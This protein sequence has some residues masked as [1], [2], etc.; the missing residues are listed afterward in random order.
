MGRDQMGSID[1]LSA[2]G[3]VPPSARCG[4]TVWGST[5]SAARGITYYSLA[6]PIVYGLCQAVH[7]QASAKPHR[8][9]LGDAAYRRVPSGTSLRPANALV[10]RRVPPRT[11]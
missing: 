7:Q 11:N 4:V 8:R 2:E 6:E 9:L 1:D 5:C 3:R 10:Y